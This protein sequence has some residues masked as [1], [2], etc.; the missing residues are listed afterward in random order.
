MEVDFTSSNKI[1][2]GVRMMKNVRDHHLMS[3]ENFSKKNCTAD[4]G[5]LTKTL[6]YDVMRQARV[7]AAVA[8]VNTSN[9][10]DRI[11]HAMALLIF[12]AF[13]VPASAINSMLSAIENMKFFLRT[14]FGDSTKFVS[15]G[16]CIKT[17]G[18]TDR[19]S[20]V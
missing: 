14:G 10:Y 6:F 11:V 13:G 1:V 9:C 15:G 12:Q 20:V 5:T 4:D 19:K 18:L 7:P 16:I 8:S 17:Q 3:E 2:Y